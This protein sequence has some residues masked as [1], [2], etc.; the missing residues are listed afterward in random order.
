MA[1]TLKNLIECYKKGEFNT[2]NI[3]LIGK[4]FSNEIIYLP[5]NDILVNVTFN[6]ALFKKSHLTTIKFYSGSFGSS[7]F[8]DCL[9]ENCVFLNI[10][11]EEME[12]LKC[13]FKDCVF[14]DCLF[15]ESRISE[16]IFENCTFSKGSVDDSDFESC[17][18]INTIFRDV[19]FGFATLIDSKF[20]NSK[21][22]IEFE[23]EVFFHDIFD[24]IDKLDLD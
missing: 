1:K 21:K 10:H 8:Q 20:S 11:F 23:G 12:S 4:R 24:Q 6:R 17:H 22:S 13:I 16:T 18:F 9:L 3:Q 2:P 5:D 15:I 7:F 19:Y 14:I